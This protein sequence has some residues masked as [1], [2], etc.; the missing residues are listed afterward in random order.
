LQIEAIAQH[1]A[2]VAGAILRLLPFPLERVVTGPL[3]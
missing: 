1:Y 3:R 2:A